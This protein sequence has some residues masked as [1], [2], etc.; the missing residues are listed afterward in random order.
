MT[1]IK[2]NHLT[3]DG[4]VRDSASLAEDKLDELVRDLVG[5]LGMEL[6]GEPVCRRVE[7]EPA[8]L[9]T[10]ED[11]GGH[12]LFALI[13]TSHIAFHVWPLRKAFMADVFSCKPFDAEKALSVCRQRLDCVVTSSRLIYRDD[14]RK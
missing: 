13:T 1:E 2:G 14:P 10:K 6:L 5:V 7:L 8:K 3:L 4:Y 9:K 12:T 11:E